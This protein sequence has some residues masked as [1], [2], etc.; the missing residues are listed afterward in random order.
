MQS[1]KSKRAKA[2]GENPSSD[3]NPTEKSGG[4][5]A[6]THGSEQAKSRA[7]VPKLS[8]DGH[9][10]GGVRSGYAAVQTHSETP[11]QAGR[12]GRTHRFDSACLP[13]VKGMLTCRVDQRLRTIDISWIRDLRVCN[14]SGPVRR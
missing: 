13:Y 5:H 3:G 4:T 1:P 2:P 7:H 14:R 12:P 6:K 10:A 9:S 11:S 8:A